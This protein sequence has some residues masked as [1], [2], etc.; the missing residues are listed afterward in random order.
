[1]KKIL[2]VDDSAFMRN[3]LKGIIVDNA[4]M[5]NPAE[6]FEIYEADGKR[7]ALMLA[8]KINPDVILLDIVMQESEME[9]IEFIEE[10]NEFFDLSKIVMISSV[11]HIDILETCKNLGIKFYVQKPFEQSEVIDSI[12]KILA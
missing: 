8:K 11:G 6:D 1:M 7:N 9:G 10:A 12:K 3:V 4:N 5:T 2:I